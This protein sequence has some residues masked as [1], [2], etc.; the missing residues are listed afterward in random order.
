MALRQVFPCLTLV[1]TVPIVMDKRTASARE[2]VLL[3]NGDLETC[4]GESGGR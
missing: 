4:L 2:V 3:N 1:K